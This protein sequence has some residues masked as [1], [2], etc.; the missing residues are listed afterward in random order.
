MAKNRKC[1]RNKIIIKCDKCKHDIRKELEDYIQCDKCMKSFHFNCSG[2]RRRAFEFFF[3]NKEELFVCTNCKQYKITT[4]DDELKEELFV[5]KTQLKKL[6]KFERIDESIKFMFNKFD[7]MFKEV[8]ENRMKIISLEKENKKLAN[9]IQS[10][11]FSVR[12]LDNTRVKNHCIVKGQKVQNY[13]NA[14]DTVIGLSRK[15]GIA[16]EPSALEDA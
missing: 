4:D 11:K 14:I 1:A 15:I 5:I 10:L 2:L 8:A 6:E 9:E 3:K 16:I 7:E 12:V 13:E